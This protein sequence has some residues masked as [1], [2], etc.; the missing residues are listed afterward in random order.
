MTKYKHLEQTGSWI[1]NEEDQKMCLN[2][3]PSVFNQ[4]F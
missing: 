1:V 4:L 3:T 2:K